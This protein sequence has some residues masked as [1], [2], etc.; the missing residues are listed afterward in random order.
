MPPGHG[1]WAERMIHRRVLGRPEKEVNEQRGAAGRA[2]PFGALAVRRIRA[3]AGLRMVLL[4][5]RS[6]PQPGQFRI[7]DSWIIRLIC[8][9][10]AGLSLMLARRPTRLRGPAAA[11]HRAFPRK[12]GARRNGPAGH[13]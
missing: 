7:R 6:E 8:D 9:L 2:G 4:E 12:R 11:C 1:D 5:R 13:R 10:L 3:A